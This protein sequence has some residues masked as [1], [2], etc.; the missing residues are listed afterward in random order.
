MTFPFRL[1]CSI[2]FFALLPVSSVSSETQGNTPSREKAVILTPKE[3]PKPRINGARV[4]GVRPG[5]PFLFTIPATGD[6]PMTFAAENL[7]KGLKLESRTGQITGTIQ[8]RGE[9][10]VTLQASN[11]AGTARRNLNQALRDHM[12][13]VAQLR[14]AT[15]AN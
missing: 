2:V 11:A 3:S 6:R 14:H 8:Q 5:S 1:I 15:G 12:A 7:P 13:A 9:Y 10:V 4:F